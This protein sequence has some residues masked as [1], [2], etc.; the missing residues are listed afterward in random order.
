MITVVGSE[1]WLPGEITPTESLE[2]ESTQSASAQ[3]HPE[4]SDDSERAPD[5]Y[6]G[7]IEKGIIINKFW[8]VPKKVL[9]GRKSRMRTGIYY[10][11]LFM[12]PTKAHLDK[13]LG[14]LNAEDRRLLEPYFDQI[15]Y[16]KG[17]QVPSNLPDNEHL[18]FNVIRPIP[19]VSSDPKKEK[20][21]KL[22]LDTALAELHWYTR[23]EHE[24][25]EMIQVNYYS[26]GQVFYFLTFTAKKLTTY[27]L[28]KFQVA[29]H[30][31]EYYDPLEEEEVFYSAGGLPPSHY[32]C[33]VSYIKQV[34][35]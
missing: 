28:Q 11:G 23:H 17:F 31:M 3:L 1:S 5:P 32:F 16:S 2:A 8:H 15:R 29:L 27:K 7:D 35:T 34:P 26:S 12:A 9:T 13:F 18:P 33:D 6:G 4:I 14:T 30:L 20:E 25:E 19:D 21:V 24:F 22:C 10:K